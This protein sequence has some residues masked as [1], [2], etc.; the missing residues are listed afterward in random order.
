METG[1]PCGK[2]IIWRQQLERASPPS[3]KD[4]IKVLKEHAPIH[5]MDV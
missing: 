2:Q 5:M 3:E 1:E 4:N